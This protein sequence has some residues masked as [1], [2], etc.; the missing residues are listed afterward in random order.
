MA[1]SVCACCSGFISSLSLFAQQRAGANVAGII[2]IIVGVMFAALA[3]LDIIM[4]IK[5]CS[6]LFFRRY[7]TALPG[8]CNVDS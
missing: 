4:L 5:V 3:F 2:M 7:Q 1:V 8:R 6:A